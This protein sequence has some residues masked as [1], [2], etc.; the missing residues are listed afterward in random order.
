M[1]S[2]DILKI[3]IEKD[4]WAVLDHIVKDGSINRVLK[5]SNYLASPNLTWAEGA[6]GFV[7]SAD[8]SCC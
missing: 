1:V 3:D 5:V 4:E 7:I 8:F 6:S 2:V